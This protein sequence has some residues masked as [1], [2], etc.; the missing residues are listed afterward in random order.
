MLAGR[1]G[2]FASVTDRCAGRPSDGGLRY[3]PTLIPAPPP[4]PG[5]SITPLLRCS[6][7]RRLNG[8]RERRSRPAFAPTGLRQLRNAKL[9]CHKPLRVHLDKLPDGSPS[10]TTHPSAERFLCCV[11]D[12]FVPLGCKAFSPIRHARSFSDACC[13]RRRTAP[14]A[15]R[16]DRLHISRF[17]SVTL[18]PCLGALGGAHARPRPSTVRTATSGGAWSAAGSGSGRHPAGDRARPLPRRVCLVWHRPSPS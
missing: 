5:G 8:G 10:G 6:A 13:R 11:F 1:M 9:T 7:A 14:N 15:L 17:A 18:R 4:S 16:L 12:E 3:N 2:G